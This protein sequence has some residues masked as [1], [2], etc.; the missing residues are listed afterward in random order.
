MIQ[1]LLN[2]IL[3]SYQELPKPVKTQTVR[4]LISTQKK[5]LQ[6]LSLEDTYILAD[7]L[8]Q[9]DNRHLSIAAFQI[10]D[11]QAKHYNK[12]TFFV[13]ENIVFTYI[14]DWWDCDDFMTH[15]FMRLYRKYPLILSSVERWTTHKNFAVRRCAPVLLVIPARKGNIPTTEVFHICDLVLNDRHYLVQKGYGW[16][17]KEASKHHPTEVIHYLEKHLDSMPRTAFRYA[18]EKLPKS[19]KERLMSLTR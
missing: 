6:T 4:K 10:L 18:L 16:L 14:K 7:L 8:L 3:D 1:T 13:F 19:E 2:R 17:L 5:E 15:A 9:Q 12:E 11:I